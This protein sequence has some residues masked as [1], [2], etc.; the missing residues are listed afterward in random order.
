MAY[1]DAP[2][3]APLPL[4]ETKQVKWEFRCWPERM[5]EALVGEWT[6][7]EIRTDTYLV[8]PLRRCQIRVLGQERFELK[9]NLETR[10]GYELWSREIDAPFPLTPRIVH[11]ATS[12]HMSYYA[13]QDAIRLVNFIDLCTSYRVV[14]VHKHRLITTMGS[15]QIVWSRANIEG[16][17]SL[18][19]ALESDNLDEL[20]RVVKSLGLEGQKNCDYGDH[21][22]ALAA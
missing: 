7:E 20:Q 1:S 17:T 22:R 4:A 2:M 5:P 15:T 19:L 10:D 6:D 8:S 3:L 16:K 12:L 13:C 9:V 18:S 14:E 11:E 21:L